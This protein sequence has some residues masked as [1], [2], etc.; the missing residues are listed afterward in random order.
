[1]YLQKVS[2][3]FGLS[4]ECNMVEKLI[5]LIWFKVQAWKEFIHF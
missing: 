1:M 4:A 3:F 5:R 2:I